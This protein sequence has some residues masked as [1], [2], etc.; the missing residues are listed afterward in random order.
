[1]LFNSRVDQKARQPRL[2]RNVLNLLCEKKRRGVSTK[3]E[4][5]DQEL[6]DIILYMCTILLEIQSSVRQFHYRLGIVFSLR[7]RKYSTR[8]PIRDR[9]LIT[10]SYY[11]EV[12]T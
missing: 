11:F 7:N 2:L 8:S 5:E 9:D 3:T 4:R 1:M 12:Y 10:V 6:L